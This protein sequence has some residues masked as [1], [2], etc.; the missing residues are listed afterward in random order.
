MGMVRFLHWL[1]GKG[2]PKTA[3]AAAERPSTRLSVIAVL[4]TCAAALFQPPVTTP[5]ATGV[6]VEILRTKQ[7][8]IILRDRPMEGP[9][10]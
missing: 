10:N 5:T 2:V 4:G 1:V 9:T 3:G 7:A 8:P 6:P